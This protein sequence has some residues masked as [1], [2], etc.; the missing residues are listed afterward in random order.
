METLLVIALV[1]MLAGPCAFAIVRRRRAARVLATAVIAE[2]E[3]PPEPEPQ[4]FVET[5]EPPTPAPTPTPAAAQDLSGKTVADL[6]LGADEL[7]WLEST[8]SVDDAID[9][10]IASPHS[11][12][13][14]ADGSL[15]RPLGVIG[16]RALADAA[17]N[18][19]Q[20][21]LGQLA[22][23]AHVTSPAQ[24]VEVLLDEIRERDEQLAVV[25]DASGA[26]TGAITV[27]DIL[28]DLVGELSDEVL[29][30]ELE[31]R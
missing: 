27:E 6:L 13:V 16:I 25:L 14:V 24:P 1:I 9:R 31:R 19:P 21:P 2:P 29:L 12:Y 23:P 11:S 30:A 28:E 5:T 7:V 15:Q 20:T 22:R 10:M 17:R 4:I 3:P 8:A 18:A 26:V